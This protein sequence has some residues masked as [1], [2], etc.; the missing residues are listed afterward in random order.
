MKNF[1]QVPNEIL[2]K[3]QLSIQSRYLLCVLL[4]YCGSKNY[5]FPSQKTLAFQCNC[6]TR[7]I[8]K[9]LSELD[10]NKIIFWE[11]KGFN[12]SNTYFVSKLY[13]NNSSFQLGTPE[14][15][16]KGSAVPAN[17]T[18]ELDKFNSSQGFE[19]LKETV[20]RLKIKK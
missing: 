3:S 13:R 10:K 7:Y 5:C 19:S 14:P 6:S 18:N 11:R 17:N 9:L 12:R 2:S 4:K 1:T 15:F 16:H 20:K 8:R